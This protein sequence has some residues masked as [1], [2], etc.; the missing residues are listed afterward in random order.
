MILNSPTISG[1]L[2][3]TGNIIASGS[4]T[5]SGSQVISGSLTV[6]T[7]SLIEFQVTNTGTKIGNAITDIH[8]VT[9]SLSVS[10]SQTFIGTKTIT[11]SVFI[12][13]SKTVIGT[14]TVTGSMLIS[15]SLDINGPITA[16]TLI[17]QTITSSVSTITGSTQFGTL[18]SNTHIFTGSMYVTGNLY[19]P[20][21]AGGVGV[22]TT[23]ISAEGNIF[24]GAKS[25]DEGGQLVFQKGT[26]YTSA[27]HLD[28]YQNRFRIMKGNDTGSTAEL[29]TVLMDSGNV[30]IGTSGPS[31]IFQVASTQS[32]AVIRSTTTTNYAEVQIEN[33]T[34]YLQIGVEGATG[35]RMGGTIA[36][37]AYLGS[38]SNYGMTFHTNNLN[39]LTISSTGAA[40]FSN[41]VKSTRFFNTFESSNNNSRNSFQSYNLNESTLTVGWIAA[42]FGDTGT[43][44]ARVVMGSGFNNKAVLGAHSGALTSWADLLISPGGGNVG[45]GM[46]TSPSYVLQIG[47]DSAGK[48]NG[49]SWA[50]SSDIR[51]KE[52]IHTI[53]NALDKITQ[54]R[55]VTFDWK[56]E[57]EQDN[58]KSSAGFI[59][60]EVMLTFPNWVKE[61]NSSDKQKELINDDKVKS[62][63]LPFEF[64]ALLVEAIKELKAQNDDLQSQINELK[65]Q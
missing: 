7:G 52:N 59:A 39:R 45:I 47:T 24:L 31:S 49:G 58:I 12:S 62:L 42:D 26:S 64:D 2:T 32:L 10:G 53:D 25:T 55:G 50:N 22:G 36:Y 34:N 23:N 14:N 37:N 41:T 48:P 15:G 29:M 60:D 57:T 38:Y 63:T 1:S 27:S 8:T 18:S 11:G 43:T 3:V 56:D 33:T 51:L 19:V 16:T 4:I 9:G 35:N 54:L 5:M 17:V 46:T 6:F 28:N 40:T 20:A 65:A 21:T 61:I 30:G 44:S 13:G